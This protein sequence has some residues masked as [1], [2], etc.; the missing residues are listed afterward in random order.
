MRFS[1]S[2]VDR[3][4]IQ[5]NG[6]V[7]V[8]ASQATNTQASLVL[9]NNDIEVEEIGK[10]LILSSPNGTRYRITVSDLGVLSTTVV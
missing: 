7:T 2:S 10:G 9:K 6:Q 5:A 3:L 1:T 4:I 8:G